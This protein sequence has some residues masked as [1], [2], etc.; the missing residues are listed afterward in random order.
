MA[1]NIGPKIGIDGEAEYRKQISAITK[2]TKL[3]NSKM[4]ALSSGFDSNGKSLK[5]N[6]EQQ[7][8]LSEQVKNQESRVEAA[9]NMVAK[10]TAA[11]ENNKKQL[12]LAKAAYGENS[13]EVQNFE[14]AVESNSQKIQKYQTDLNN[15]TADLNN[16]KSQLDQLPSSLDLV[17]QKFKAMGKKMESIGSAMTSL[18]TKLTSTVTTGI[19]GAFTAAVKTTGDFDEAMSQ[20]QAVSGATA[21]DLA[22]LRAKAK[23][24]GETTKFSAS[25]SAE[26]LNYMAMAGWKTDDMLNGLEGIMNLA[27]ASGEELGTTSDIVTDALTAF[28]MSADE[29]A[30]FADILAAAASNS[31][32]NVSMMGES[33]KYAAPVAGALG[34]SA[35]DVAVA[36]GLMANS[37]IKADQ[38]GTSLRNMFN[39]MAKPTKES[40]AAMDR[41]GIELYDGEGEMFTFREIMDQLRASMSDINMP[42]E[43]YNAALDELDEQLADGTLTQKKYDAALE[44]LNLQA[45]GAEGAEKARAAAMLGGTRAMSGLLA[46]SNATEEDYEKL[47][48]AIDNSSQSFAK[49]ADGSVVPLS[50]A[51][52]DGSEIIETYN[53]SAEA[54]ANTM[55]DNLPGQLTIL[56]SQIEGIAISFG[57]ILMPK[58]REV[59]SKMQELAD[60]IKQLSPEQKEQI[61]KIAAIA[62]AIGPLLLAGGKLISGIGKIMT[63][64][65]QI[66]TALQGVSS[67]FGG[68]STSL[69]GAL[70]PITAIV[71]VIGVLVAAFMNLWNNNE[72]FRTNM[73]ATWESIKASFAGFIEQIQERL[74]AIQEAF[75]NFIEFVRPLWEAFCQVLAP[76]FE[77][78]FSMVATVLQTVFNLIISVIDMLLGIFTMDKELFMTGLTEFLTAIVTFLTTMLNLIWT[79]ILNV[80]NVILSFFGTSLQTLKTNITTAFTN[81]VTFVQNKITEFRDLIFEKVGEVVDYISE[82]P[83]KFLQWG[84]DMINNLIA[85]IRSGIDAV[86]E[87][88]GAVAEK[89]S[90]FLHFSEPDVGPLAN[91]NSWMPDMMKQ[92]ADQI[93]AG[94]LQV[95]L[96]A[97]HVAA[98]IAAPMETAQNFTL[99]NSFTFNGGYTEA[100]GREIVRR[101]NRELGSLY[102]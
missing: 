75:T 47:T 27:A 22:L 79:T 54:M 8:I 73:I 20:V 101:I 13:T 19:V 57:E 88:V 18:G 64:A 63:F 44:E 1:V 41:L 40:A 45:F 71:A 91:F 96:A 9:K 93:E 58:V 50:Q 76:M 84:T 78:A 65:P 94:R 48:S 46:I 30:H 72:A 83:G 100:D 10:A 17:A 24:M 4:K 55:L 98:D 23:E 89:I 66:A 21:S 37:G 26:A 90:S 80:V 42:L 87:A 67:I 7:K 59:V 3:L 81:I 5:Q 38:A 12:E 53:G 31:N 102:I 25:E 70:A 86:G 34:Y 97:S 36:L 52:A 56:K 43:D 49:L 62:A 29:S 95:Q 14:K 35:E 85:G 92:M 61:V 11:Y 69:I 28:G 68:F 6:A 32:T 99:N 82:L 39:R 60:K 15:A 51:L 2:E 33:F 74:P 77:G 16:L